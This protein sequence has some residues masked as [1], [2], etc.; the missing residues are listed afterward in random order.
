MTFLIRSAILFIAL[1]LTGCGGPEITSINAEVSVDDF[2]A[3]DAKLERNNPIALPNP[4]YE[5]RVGDLWRTSQWSVLAK[6]VVENGYDID[7]NWFLL[8]EAAKGGGFAEAARIY[9][10]K[11]YDD[12]ISTDKNRRCGMFNK[13]GMCIGFVFPRDAEQRLRN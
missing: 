8:G 12:S 9:Y 5:R 2:I 3:G 1:L 10:K 11:A 7:L 13:W 6:E 4:W